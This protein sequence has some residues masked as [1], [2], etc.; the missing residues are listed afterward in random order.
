MQRADDAGDTFNGGNLVN[1][2]APAV[3]QRTSAAATQTV[4]QPPAQRAQVECEYP[5]PRDGYHY[6]AGPNY[7]AATGCGLVL[8]PD[9]DPN[10]CDPAQKIARAGYTCNPQGRWQ[11]ILQTVG[12]QVTDT[13][14]TITQSVNAADT[15]MAKVQN[16]PWW[17][18]VLGAG[19]LYLFAESD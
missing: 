1:V 18:W 16:I 11:Q 4:T 9:V 10:A 14:Q 3:F 2:L 5:A 15:I 7:D 6:E 19:L 17:Q 12:T 13:T 8:V